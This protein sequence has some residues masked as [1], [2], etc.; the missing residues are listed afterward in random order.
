MI[1]T[2]FL[3]N[4]SDCLFY[5]KEFAQIKNT[6]KSLLAPGLTSLLKKRVTIRGG[7]RAYLNT[8]NGCRDFLTKQKECDGWELSNEIPLMLKF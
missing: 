6:V 5:C 2:Q 8:Q 1:E 4:H 7:G 3:L